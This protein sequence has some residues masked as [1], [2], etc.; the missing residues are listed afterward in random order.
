MSF[1]LSLSSL[2]ES[3]AQQTRHITWNSL[4]L[5]EECK[6][7]NACFAREVG[8]P[9]LHWELVGRWYVNWLA[10]FGRKRRELDE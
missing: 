3:L 7:E 4:N 10:L 6:R 2:S 8:E 1:T 9:H 5:V